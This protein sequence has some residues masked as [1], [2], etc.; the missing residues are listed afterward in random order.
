MNLILRII[1]IPLF[2]TYC[3]SD[4]QETPSETV[5][6]TPSPEITE[7]KA[8]ELVWSDEFDGD[9][10]NQDH[11]SFALGD[12][13][14]NLCGWGNNELQLYT[15]NNHRL[16]DGMLV[17]TAKKE[18]DYTST[19]ILTKG[20]KEFQY[21]R[22][23]ARVKV[24]VGAG[25][26]PAFWALGNDID[27]NPWPDCGEIDIME[28][29]GRKPGEIFTSVH[30]RSSYGDTVNTKITPF[31]GIEDDFHVFAVEWTNTS[32]TFFV[33]DQRLYTY[34]PQTRNQETWPFD[35]PVFLLIN[36][37][38]GGNF[39]GAVGADTVFPQDYFIDYVRVYQ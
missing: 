12:G 21:G 24:P 10:L 38:I 37:A 3:S 22:I 27:S 34:T 5:V 33:D 6:A 15:D 23:E 39:G 19:R 18:E 11:W 14:P 28:Y 32:L 30:T 7:P 17:I 35:K 26:W 13:C 4:K 31:P 25:L 20:K 29:V 9:T 1:F 16:E 8:L 2:F 36:L